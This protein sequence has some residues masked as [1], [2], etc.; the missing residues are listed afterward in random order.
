MIAVLLAGRRSKPREEYVYVLEVEPLVSAEEDVFEYL[1]APYEKFAE[2]LAENIRLKW[3]LTAGRLIAYKRAHEIARK[4]ITWLA[5]NILAPP[6]QPAKSP[7]PVGARSGRQ[8]RE[9]E[10]EEA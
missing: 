3:A 10:E 9:G 1:A 4:R 6:R 8:T 2:V 7:Q 5:R